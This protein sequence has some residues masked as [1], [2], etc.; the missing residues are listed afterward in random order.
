M[1]TMGC[2]YS[3]VNARHSEMPEYFS[4]IALLTDRH[5]PP[6]DALALHGRNMTISPHLSLAEN[7][8]IS[9]PSGE[10]ARVNPTQEH[11]PC[12]RKS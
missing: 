6:S 10:G 5:F 8:F 12:G 7:K 11:F 2:S 9:A 1:A 4:L 3:I